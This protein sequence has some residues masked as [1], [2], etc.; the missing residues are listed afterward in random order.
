[1]RAAPHEP[2]VEAQPLPEGQQAQAL[3]EEH[4][5][6]PPAPAPVEPEA[7]REYLGGEQ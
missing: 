7:V 2:V 3:P 1:M 4:H 5:Q 6:E